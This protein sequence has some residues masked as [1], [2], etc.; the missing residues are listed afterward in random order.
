[1]WKNT[2]QTVNSANFWGRKQL[3]AR[4]GEIKEICVYV[5]CITFVIIT[6]IVIVIMENKKLRG[7]G[8]QQNVSARSPIA[9]SV[10]GSMIPAATPWIHHCEFCLGCTSHRLLPANDYV[11]GIGGWEGD[12]KAG[13]FLWQTKLLKLQFMIC[14][15]SLHPSHPSNI[16]PSLPPFCLPPQPPPSAQ[17]LS[18]TANFSKSFPFPTPSPSSL[19]GI[20]APKPLAPLTPSLGLPFRG[21]RL[22]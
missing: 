1:M 12:T 14:L 3:Q 19:T 15:P 13:L 22:T 18:L 5:L 4:C 2:H 10:T 9:E 11:G 6:I 21:P 7:C 20:L 17:H 16:L 8:G